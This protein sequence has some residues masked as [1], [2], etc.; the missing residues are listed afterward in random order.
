M[1][2]ARY[3][4]CM[5]SAFRM[6]NISNKSM[7]ADIHLKITS[8]L[9]VSPSKYIVSRRMPVTKKIAATRDNNLMRDRITIARFRVN[10][11]EWFLAVKRLLMRS[12]VSFSLL[13][14]V[15]VVIRARN[16]DTLAP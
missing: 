12:L 6:P 4:L 3:A 5:L 2:I 8:A 9:K 16:T 15:M 13:T 10:K 14:P 7:K 11:G 1:N